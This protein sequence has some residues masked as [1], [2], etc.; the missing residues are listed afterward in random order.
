MQN[1]Q[2]LVSDW[3]YGLP[4][5]EIARMYEWGS[6]EMGLFRNVTLK[7]W[8]FLERGLCSNGTLHEWG[9]EGIWLAGMGHC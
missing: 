2:Y 4:T 8:D 5:D 6:T 1:V 3:I 7:E 9:S